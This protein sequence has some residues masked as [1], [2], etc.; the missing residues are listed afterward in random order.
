MEKSLAVA[1]LILA[2]QGCV[3]WPDK[4]GVCFAGELVSAPQNNAEAKAIEYVKRHEADA[5]IWGVCSC[6]H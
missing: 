1:A 4:S 2:L 6:Q 5:V 3:N